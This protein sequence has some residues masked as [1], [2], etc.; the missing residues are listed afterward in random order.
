MT[1][2]IFALH[3]GKAG[4]ACLVHANCDGIIE[5]GHT[6]GPTQWAPLARA[7][8]DFALIRA[9]RCIINTDCL[10]VA[11]GLK[12][13]K[14]PAPDKYQYIKYWGQVGF[15]GDQHHWKV[16]MELQRFCRYEGW[17]VRLLQPGKLAA[18]ERLV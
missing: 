1:T 8:T 7:M 4:G 18:V 14:A 12:T 3:Y 10:P 2:L 17:E 15:G 11:Q 16:L 6:T 5:L 13:F 9:S